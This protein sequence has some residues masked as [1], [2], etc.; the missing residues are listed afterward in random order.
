[1]E[2]IARYLQQGEYTTEDGRKIKLDERVKE[3]LRALGY[4]K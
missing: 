2:S 3:Q 1:M 4:L